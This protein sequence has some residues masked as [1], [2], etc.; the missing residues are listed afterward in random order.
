MEFLITKQAWEILNDRPQ[1][2]IPYF[3]R[4]LEDLLSNGMTA[5]EMGQCT[6]EQIT[7]TAY[8]MFRKEMLEGGLVQLIYNGYGPFIFLNPFAKALRQWGLK[9]FSGFIYD[10]RR[11]YEAQRGEIE[12][13][14]MS[15]DDFMAL[16]EA[17]PE[18]DGYD[19][20]FVEQEPEISLEI[21]NFVLQNRDKFK[22]IISLV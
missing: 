4:Q 10:L 17:H 12:G 16:Y 2:V 3:E 6:P 20:D 9:D 1:E 5:E 18:M 13:R 19:D 8:L 14:D 21:A 22:I 11:V 15:D 7:L